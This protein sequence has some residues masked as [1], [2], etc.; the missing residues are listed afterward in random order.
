MIES[1][2]ICQYL[3]QLWQKLDGLLCTVLAV[4]KHESA[5]EPVREVRERSD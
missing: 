1:V 2:T 4:L 3:M 5:N